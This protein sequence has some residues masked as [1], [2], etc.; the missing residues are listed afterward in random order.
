MTLRRI[1]M[2]D[3]FAKHVHEETDHDL[4]SGPLCKGNYMR[5]D[6]LSNHCTDKCSELRGAAFSR[7]DDDVDTFAE[8]VEWIHREMYKYITGTD[9]LPQIEKRRL[10]PMAPT[11][12]VCKPPIL[13]LVGLPCE[14][15]GRPDGFD[16]TDA[17][18]SSAAKLRMKFKDGTLYIP[19]FNPT[20]AGEAVIVFASQDDDHELAMRRAIDLVD[21]MDQA[22][23]L[24][25][26]ARQ[27]D[28][29]IGAT[30]KMQ[31]V[32]PRQYQD[33]HS[34]FQKS[35]SKNWAKDLFK[36]VR[37]EQAS[38]QLASPQTTFPLALD[39]RACA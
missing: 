37:H 16:R 1:N 39:A 31:F 32:T 19:K 12:L 28:N 15:L 3:E 35:K 27:V 29:E 2:Y 18:L 4:D 30:A 33:W 38:A 22:S 7:A 11:V 14:K 21:E 5:H 6:Q 34:Q 23:S 8:A 24:G 10:A 20:F 9:S 25:P 17:C 36:K 13:H 26:E